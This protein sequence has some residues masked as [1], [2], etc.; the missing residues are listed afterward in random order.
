MAPG[1]RNRRPSRFEGYAIFFRG[2]GVPGVR[3]WVAQCRGVDLRPYRTAPHSGGD[4]LTGGVGGTV[5]GRDS[6]AR[7]GCG[8]DSSL[9]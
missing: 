5:S 1:E 7:Q 3:E 2:R 9:T 8:V 6:Q 4:G